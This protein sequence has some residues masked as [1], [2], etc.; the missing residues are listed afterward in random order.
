MRLSLL[1]TG[2]ESLADSIAIGTAAEAAGFDGLYVVEAYRSGW[3]PLAA[4]AGATARVR[5]G[6]YVLNGYARSPMMTAM[7]AAD[8]QELSGGRL[9]LGMGGGNAIINETWQGVPHAR[10]LAKMRDTV[11]ILRRAAR[12]AAGDELRWEGA[13]HRMAWTPRVGPGSAYPVLLA[14]VFPAM[15]K[16]A[17]ECADGIAGG[18]TLGADWLGGELA[19]RTRSL[20]AAA[21]LD[22]APPWYAVMFTAVSA[23]RERARRAVRAALCSLF[24]PLRHPYYEYTMNEQGFASTVAALRTLVPAGRIDEAIE[25]IPDELLDRLTVAGTPS[26]CRARLLTYAGVVDELLL[27]NA[28]PAGE[29]GWR[30]AWHDL[31]GL[32]AAVRQP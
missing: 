4:L 27:I 17:A 26:E 8:F 1:F 18:A 30:S 31:L 6:T 9:V 32:P 12:T 22:G 14:A 11:G 21:G 29:G 20:A 5:L 2:V 7:S 28:L 19:P 24:H 25:A 13:V 10:V 23:E 3:V 15:L 16:V